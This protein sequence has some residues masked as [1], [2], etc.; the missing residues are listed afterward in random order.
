MI[1]GKDT[2]PLKPKM[3]ISYDTT[4]EGGVTHIKSDTFYEDPCPR[5]EKINGKIANRTD[6]SCI[7]QGLWITTDSLGNYFTSVYIDGNDF[8]ESKKYSKSGKLLNETKE[9]S[10]GKEYYIVKKI[11]YSSGKPVTI[12]NMPLFGF[13]IE[14]FSILVPILVVLMIFRVLINYQIYNIENETNYSSFGNHFKFKLYEPGELRH[15]L[16]SVFTLWFFKYKPENK[17][18]VIIS[19]IFSILCFGSVAILTIGLKVCS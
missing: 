18:R 17:Y 19:N 6:S 16:F 11:D 4:R 13:Y 2:L 9:V 14:N 5:F 3:I 1:V 8:G 7:Q 10:L 12:V 15:R